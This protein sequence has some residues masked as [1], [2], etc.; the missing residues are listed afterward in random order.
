MTKTEMA[1][2]L[3]DM[4]RERVQPSAMT[5]V[6][7]SIYNRNFKDIIDDTIVKIQETVEQDIEDEES[8]FEE[9]TGANFGHVIM[10]GE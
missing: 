10:E 7:Q 5:E 8:D 9:E 1:E 2:F 4:L 6:E 3:Q